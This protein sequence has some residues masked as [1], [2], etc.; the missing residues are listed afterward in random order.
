MEEL[1]SSQ[2]L[3]YSL[4]ESNPLL[5]QVKFEFDDVL[6]RDCMQRALDVAIGRYPYFRTRLV[7]AGERLCLAPNDAPMLVYDDPDAPTLRASENNGYLLRVA[8]KDNLLSICGCHAIS[9]GRG[10][11]P[12]FKTLLHYYWLSATGEDPGLAGVRLA[13]TP[14]T[15]EES[16]DPLR[17]FVPPSPGEA[18]SYAAPA[19]RPF[20][21]PCEPDARSRVFTYRFS[22]DAESYMSHSRAF[23]GSPNALTAI[24]ASQAIDAIHPDHP[25]TIVGRVTAD[26]RP[27][28]GV[29][30][31]HHCTICLKGLPYSRKVSSMTLEERAT[32]YRGMIIL[33]CDPDALRGTVAEVNA[34]AARIQA[35]PT[36]AQ[37]RALGRRI[38]SEAYATDTFGVSYTGRQD[39][40]RI[41]A[42]VV[43]GEVLTSIPGPPLCIEIL[44]FGPRFYFTLIQSFESEAYVR[45]LMRQMGEAGIACDGYSR[46]VQ[47]RV[48]FDGIEGVPVVS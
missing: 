30:E 33:R 37:K 6:D 42:H 41:S 35:L 17:A 3:F 26:L 19:V 48:P 36:F 18:F 28:V 1:W 32:C 22:C 24:F 47:P 29:S 44:C 45:E 4:S 23:D 46:K 10:L 21:L 15:R 16:D 34:A 31:S 38:V 11:F 14:V 5:M 13:G 2:A 39:L 8:A 20:V 25:D 7:R 40:G 9:D 12:F 27:A 43:F